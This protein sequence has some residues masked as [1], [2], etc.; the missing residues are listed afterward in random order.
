[1]FIPM[2]ME[3]EEKPATQGLPKTDKAD[4]I[5]EAALS[6][7]AERGFH[8]VTVPEIA[9]RAKVGAGTIY[10]YFASKEELVNAVYRAEKQRLSEAL[11][12]GLVPER[13]ARAVYHHFWTRAWAFARTAPTSLQFLELHHHAPYLDEKSRRLEQ[14]LFETTYLLIASAQ[15]SQALKP[16]APPLL[17]ALVWGAFRGL[18]QASV[19]GRIEANDQVL[20]EVEQALWEAIRA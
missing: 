13:T 2:A 11:M 16:I 19:E 17:V 18:V 5:Q 10:R 3:T 12:S 20:G 1:M 7:F 4:A 14:E 6:L 8:G 15:K 9:Q